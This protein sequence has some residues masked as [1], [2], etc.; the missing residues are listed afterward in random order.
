[1]AEKVIIPVEAQTEKANAKLKE[2]KK[3]VDNVKKSGDELKGAIDKLS[4]GMIS[5]FQGGVKSVKGLIGG[6]K[7]L[8]GA[9]I[10]TGLGALVVLV[11][12]LVTAFQ[13]NQDAADKM[14]QIFARIGAVVDILMDLIADFGEILVDAFT[15]PQ[16]AIRDLWEAIKKNLLNRMQGA[17]DAFGALGRAIKAALSL[18]WDGV[19]KA[20]KDFGSA[21]VQAFTGLDETQRKN[22]VNFIKDTGKEMSIAA[23]AA[24]ALKKRQQELRDV[25]IQ[26][27]KTDAKLRASIEMKRLAAEEEGLAVSAQIALLEEADAME[28][29][30][31]NDRQKRLK[32]DIEITKAKQRLSKNMTADNEELARMEAELIQIEGQ[33][34]SQRVRLTRRLNS[35]RKQQENEER[36]FYDTLQKM[37]IENM[38]DARKKLEA[39]QK[40]ELEELRRKYGE[41]T[42]LE[43]ELVIKQKGELDK[44]NAELREKELEQEQLQLENE[45]MRL[46]ENSEIRFQKQAELLQ[47]ERDLKLDNDNLTNAERERIELEFNQKLDAI[48]QARIDIAQREA[49]AKKMAQM[50]VMDAVAMGLNGIAQAAGDNKAIAIAAAT[51]DTFVAANKA[52]AQLGPIAGPIAA[53]GIVASGIANVRKIASTNI[54]NDNSG[55]GSVPTATGFDAVTQQ[56]FDAFQQNTQAPQNVRDVTEREPVQAFVLEGDVT[57]SQ[58]TISRLR[59]R[60]RI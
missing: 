18:D 58:S 17:I 60:Q 21:T 53:T 11:G 50:E 38:D 25:N 19:T 40:M 14:N 3:Q 34:A 13:R 44:L 45:L 55:S 41:Q 31:L 26:A 22:F 32:E 2:T 27:I 24:D 7:S 16:Q 15:N 9:I 28:Q 42:E 8:K 46:D 52:L 10:A 54:P 6:F 1:M 12:S 33:S 51:I 43:E 20:A 49:Q 59:Q 57:N 35:L 29:K 36:E 37:R 47:R 23:I 39:Q 48:S 30:L 5:G 4:G 56:R